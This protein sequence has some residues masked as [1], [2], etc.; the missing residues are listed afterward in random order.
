MDKEN[1]KSREYYRIKT[2]DGWDRMHFVTD[3][4]SVDAADGKSLE[5]K[6][7]NIKGITTDIDTK[8]TGY[9]LDA[10]AINGKLNNSGCS[11][12]LDAF[13]VTTNNSG[14]AIPKKI[15]GSYFSSSEITVL[16]AYISSNNSNFVKLVT[17]GINTNGDWIVRFTDGSGEPVKQ[18]TAMLILI[19]VTP[20]LFAAADENNP[21][22]SIPL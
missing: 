6:V 8:E 10:S 12:M 18:T 16:S 15:D 11:L 14:I 5:E 3:A 1:I 19:Y 4:G 20:S 21:V 9:A 13:S 2:A 17:P 7:G 22:P